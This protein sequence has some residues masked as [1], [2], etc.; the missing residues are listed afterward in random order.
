MSASA[1]V[2]SQ[3]PKTLLWLVAIGF[4][5][6]TLDGT[7]VNTA[8]PGMAVSLGESPLQLQWVVI[9]YM[10]TMAMV[11]PASGWLA[12]RFGTRRIFFSAIV[13]FVIGSTLCAASHDLNLL[14]GGRIIQGIGGAM[15]LPVGRLAVLRSYPKDQFLRAMSFVMIPGLIGPLVGPTLG[16][17][18]V[19]YASWHWIFLINIPVGIVGAIATWAAMPDKRPEGGIGSFDLP[20]Y[21]MLAI[22]MVALSLSL[23]GFASLGIGRATVVVLLIIGLATTTAYWLHAQR[24]VAPLFPPSLFRIGSFRVGILGNVFARIGSGSMPFLIPLLMQV[25][26]GYSPSE[27]GMLMLP[28]A[29]AA[30]FAKRIATGLIVRFGFRRV[31]TANTVFLGILIASFSLTAPEQPLVLRMLQLALFGA[32]NSLQFTA[33]NTVTLKDLGTHQASSGNTMLSMTQMLSM[34]LGVSVASAVLGAFTEIFSH[35]HDGNTLAAFHASFACIGIMTSAAAWIFWQ[36]ADDRTSSVSARH[37]PH[38]DEHGH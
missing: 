18:L 9:A 22:S 38:G 12:D 28:V 26:L 11:I 27:A 29:I 35:A 4:F 30:I 20:G 37:L 1:P 6:Q 32:I 14:V 10:L 24:S 15:L 17:W 31:L 2:A 34:S 23:D 16:G 8:L 3:P 36:L 5:M 19:E 13:L 33:M 25:A 7:I 21:A